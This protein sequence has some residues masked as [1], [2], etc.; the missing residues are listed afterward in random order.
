VPRQPLATEVAEQPDSLPDRIGWIGKRYL[1]AE[2]GAVTV[3]E[4]SNTQPQ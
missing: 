3:R 2:A 4:A 1:V